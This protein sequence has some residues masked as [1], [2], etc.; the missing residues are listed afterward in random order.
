LLGGGRCH[1]RHSL[2]DLRRESARPESLR[3]AQIIVL[4]NLSAHK[5]ERAKELIEERGC[6][7]LLYL[8]AYSSPEFNPIEEA[9]SKIKS[10]L[11]KAQ[12]RNREALVEALGVA[13]WA[14]TT[15]DAHGFFEHGGY[16][17]PVHLLSNTL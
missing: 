2:G 9:F 12:A 3:R 7:L 17:L 6:Q 5:S 16:H 4:D 1:N 14:V 8:P 15:R 11:R 10:A 13:I